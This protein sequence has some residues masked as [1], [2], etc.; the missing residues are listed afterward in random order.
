MSQL[1]GEYSLGIQE[2][3][4][5][6]AVGTPNIG[7]TAGFCV[8]SLFRLGVLLLLGMVLLGSSPRVFSQAVNGN[9]VGT[10]MDSSGAVVSGATVT[11]T[12][13]RENVSRSTTSNESGFYSFPD[14]SPGVYK[15][16]AE[17]AGFKNVVRDEV[18]LSVSNTAHVDLTLQPGSVNETINVE[19]SIPTL[20]T[21]NAQTGGQLS[22]SQAEQLPVS[23]GRN[24]QTLVNLVPGATRA[25]N[26]H[27]VFFN[28]QGS[29][30]S[31]VNGT[32]SMSNN[33]QIEGVNDNERT[34]LL[35]VYVPPIEAIQEVQ[36]LTSNYDAEQG[37][38]LGAVVNVIYKSGTNNFH[39]AL[40]DFYNGSALNSKSFF[41]R[42]PNGSAFHKP[43]SVYDYWGGN[44]GGPI[45]KDK[46]FFFVD[47]LRTTNHSAQFQRLSVPT[48]AERN[49]DFSDPALTQIFDP[50]TGDTADCLPGG[51]SKLCGTGRT[52]FMASSS[53]SS[54]NYNPACTPTTP[55]YNAGNCANVIPLNRLDSVAQKIMA[56]VPL[57]NNNQ[58]AAGTGKYAQNFLESTPFT[59]DNNSFDV[60]IDHY[61]GKNNHI[62][63]HL[64]YMNPITFQGPAYGLAG[65]PIGGGFQ[66]T[67]TDKTFSAA[68]NWDHIFSSSFVVQNRVGLNRY[69]NTAQ[70]NDY[71]SNASTQIGIPGVNVSPFES[72]L[73]GIFVD[74]TISNPMVGYS[75]SLPWVRAETDLDVVSNWNK[76]IGNHTIK[77]G[78]NLIRLRDDLLQEQTFSPRGAWHFGSSQTGL[79]AAGA[80]KVGF[81]NNFA[82][83]WLGVPSQVGRDL[84]I[85]FPAYREWQ[86]FTYVN[87]KWQV[88]PN[89]TLNL[90]VR[91]EFYPPGTPHFAG[92]FS[93]Y[94][95]TTNNLVV[96]GVGGNPVDLGMQKNYKDFAPRIGLAY[97]FTS[98]DVVRAGYGI[99]Y[100]PFVDNTYAYDFPVKQNNSF[101]N[102][103]GFGPAVLPNG[104]PA[105]FAAGFPAP[106]PA[107]IPSSGIIPANTPLLI[108]QS[109]DVINLKY[110][111]PYIQ[112]WNLT[113]ERA[114]PMKFTVDVAYVGNRGVRMPIQYNLNAVSNPA[115]FNTGAAG[116]PLIGFCVPG[117]T[118]CRT[119]STTERFAGASSDYNALQ[120]KFDRRVG[121]GLNVTTSYTYGK[122]LGYIEENGENS[123]GID[124][125]INFRRN[126]ARADF[127]RTH[128]FV[129]SY[130]WDLPLGKGHR[131]LAGGGPLNAIFGGW[132]FS[133]V[134]T[135][136]TGTPF[137]FGCNCHTLNTP[138][139]HQSPWVTGPITEPKG[140]DTQLWFN[141]SVFEDPYTANNNTVT[142][143]NVG[144]Y[145]LSGP[146]LFNLDSS[147]AKVF[148]LSERFSFEF[149]TDW[150]SATNT[151][152]FNNPDV[153]LGDANFGHVTGAG[154][155][156]NIYFGGRLIF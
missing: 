92:G 145:I 60:K 16:K 45:F 153:T 77:W 107:T 102:V 10:I 121:N 17:K 57:P 26:N 66:G 139:N 6:F 74:A 20:Q 4:K 144:R 137:N 150:F 114:L 82:S 154:G 113:Y 39:G 112:S 116:Q 122:S 124:Y 156:R 76:V 128:M 91:W 108:N 130:I 101:D 138:G 40:Y 30:N 99:S 50:L 95:P 8:S 13:T 149:R 115:M 133:N 18:Q 12:E 29:L 58:N 125:Y 126:Y 63:G 106:L 54:Q 146:N 142:F 148:R 9:I 64:G 19:V 87:D 89:L 27:S 59:Q 72:G 109:Y 5:R 78:G 55:T 151:P 152:Q 41:D 143:G 61:Q 120:I 15:V 98:K 135:F 75:A 65:G 71:G 132:R 31:E 47:Y 131:W 111:D 34:G 38:A 88:K 23:R 53:S 80:P 62:S 147:L 25:E 105:T 36:V 119:A 94:N 123:N 81:A 96:A 104:T 48:A 35:Q 140:V 100:E 32:S 43:H 127:D 3:V 52:Q 21:D 97:Q 93:N 73:T 90:G 33:F 134:V 14:V 141:T 83:F 24:F 56:L 11:I 37:T 44:L 84:A 70:Q 110:K 85:V 46:T 51:N 69:R 67:G 129:Q 118:T 136:M 7:R 117:T 22:S 2:R 155:A 103:S 1:W 28:P 86:V 42:G 68:V 79:N 49:G